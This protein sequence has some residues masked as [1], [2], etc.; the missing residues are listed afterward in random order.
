M[1]YNGNARNTLYMP[2]QVVER[3]TAKETRVRAQQ[4]FQDTWGSG[5]AAKVDGT[6]ALRISLLAVVI[7]GLIIN[8]I[9]E[10]SKRPVNY[11]DEV[12]LLLVETKTGT[13][14]IKEGVPTTL[15]INSYIF[16]LIFVAVGVSL[17]WIGA[18]VVTSIYKVALY[19]FAT[20]G[21]CSDEFRGIDLDRAFIMIDK[22]RAK[23][24]ARRAERKRIKSG[25]KQVM[26]FG[27][28]RIGSPDEN[29]KTQ[30]D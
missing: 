15:S 27:P 9:S 26:L 6:L 20:T 23:R 30:A 19:R 2:T 24:K 3:T 22:V 21:E 28:P 17:I 4:W 25:Q 12:H 29:H 14:W 10:N 8:H 7:I 16:G 11:P 18:V 13:S 5:R 1:V